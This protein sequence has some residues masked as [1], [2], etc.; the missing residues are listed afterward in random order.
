MAKENSGHKNLKPAKKGEVR[1]PKGRGEGNLNRATYAKMAMNTFAP[2]ELAA[3][4]GPNAELELQLFG[5]LA[6]AM[7]DGK[8]SEAI[9]AV[10]E[11]FDRTEGKSIARVEQTTEDITPPAKILL[12]GPDDDSK[13]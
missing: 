8:E 3:E 4:L 2:D 10:K 5:R 6:I 13:D 9:A 11:M 1:N 7:R 12:T